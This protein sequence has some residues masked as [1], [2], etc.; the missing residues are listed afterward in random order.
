MTDPSLTQVDYPSY[1][2]YIDLLRK[3]IWDG[4]KGKQLR[5]I[6]GKDRKVKEVEE[7]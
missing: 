4:A 7:L 2:L 3:G 6:V 5:L 1:E